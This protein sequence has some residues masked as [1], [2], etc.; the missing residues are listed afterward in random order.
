MYIIIITNHLSKKINTTTKLQFTKHC[1]AI[2]EIVLNCGSFFERKKQ[3]RKKPP[4]ISIRTWT[5]HFQNVLGNESVQVFSKESTN[6]TCLNRSLGL[7]L[8]QM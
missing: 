1:V 4:D 8:K 5:H 3:R 2:S 6:E 7:I